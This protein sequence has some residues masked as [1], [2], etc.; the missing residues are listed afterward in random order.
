MSGLLDG[1]GSDIKGIIEGG[2]RLAGWGATP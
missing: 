2:G 1:I